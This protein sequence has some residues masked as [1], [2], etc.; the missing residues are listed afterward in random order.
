MMSGK[1][2]LKRRGHALPP[3]L[4]DIRLTLH[5]KGSR[6]GID[7]ARL[8]LL[9]LLLPLSF[10]LSQRRPF[11]RVSR[12]RPP[13]WLLLLF[14]PILYR[15]LRDPLAPE[16]G[17]QLGGE[18]QKFLPV[19]TR[20]VPRD[21]DATFRRVRWIDA[22][23][24]VGDTGR[25][26]KGR[27]PEGSYGGPWGGCRGVVVRRVIGRIISASRGGAASLKDGR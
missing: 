5:L 27:V 19:T 4:V 23:R 14:R 8:L 1:N 26:E 20:N 10:T 25:R 16:L 15:R 11:D 17:L 24:R 13:L 6:P 21:G 12:A 9:L 7:F 3:V 2:R 18:G 22:G